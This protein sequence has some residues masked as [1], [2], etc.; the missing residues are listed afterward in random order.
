MKAGTYKIEVETAT[1]VE[2]L[3][4]NESTEF[5]VSTERFRLSPDQIY[6]VYPPRET[7]GNYSECL[8]HIVLNRRTL[9]WEKM[10]LSH[11]PAMP[12]LALLVFD[13][14]EGVELIEG[15]C[16]EALKP[17]AGTFVPDLILETYEKPDAPCTYVRIPTKIAAGILPFA[18]AL[19]L[20]SH[21]KGVSLDPKVTDASVTD[22]WFATVVTNRFS[23]EP[24]KDDASIRHIACLVS[25]EGYE[26]CLESEQGRRQALADCQAVRMIVLTSWNFSMA[27]AAFDFAS[28]F[29]SLDAAMIATPYSGDNQLVRLLSDLGYVPMNHQVRD[30]SR[31]VSWYQPPLIPYNEPKEEAVCARFADQWLAYDPGIGMMDIRY[32]SAWQIGKSMALADQSYAQRL[33]AWRQNNVRSVRTSVYRGLLSSHLSGYYDGANIRYRLKDTSIGKPFICALRSDQRI[34]KPDSGRQ[35]ILQQLH[36]R[37]TSLLSEVIGDEHTD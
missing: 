20:L 29:T 6:S 8:P 34:G 4:A 14:T 28:T 7:V 25:L 13:E 23:L 19:S 16:E 10:L 33:Y 17:E 15:T 22:D 12:W 2:C 21:G 26:A 30:G 36:E 24:E 31:T 18:E 5:K 9:P 27:K 3:L 1:S 35:L 11:V 32:A 37:Y